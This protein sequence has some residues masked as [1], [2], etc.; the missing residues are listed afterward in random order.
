MFDLRFIS[1]LHSFNGNKQFISFISLEISVSEIPE[2]WPSSLNLWYL[3]I[4]FFASSMV[5]SKF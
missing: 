2:S 5:F 4:N 1:R 3:D